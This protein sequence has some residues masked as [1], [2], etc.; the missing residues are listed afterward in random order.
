MNGFL[1]IDKDKGFTSHDVIQ[2]LRKKLNTRKIGHSGTLDPLATGLML[3]GVNNGCKFLEFHTHEKKTYLA[4]IHFG[5]ISN[6]YDAE[7]P[8]EDVSEAIISEEK[9]KA[10]LKEFSGLQLQIPPKYS[11]LK[12]DGQKVCNIMRKGGNIDMK[13]KERNIMI[14]TNTLISY[15]WPYIQ[16]EVA[17]SAGTYIRSLAHDIGQKLNVGA[18]LSDL[19]RTYIQDF[20]VENAQKLDQDV[21]LLP[22]DFG[23]EHD[24]IH[25]SESIYNRLK[26]GQRIGEKDF[27]DHSDGM[28]RL[29]KD[30]IFVGMGSVGEKVLHGRKVV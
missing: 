26:Q 30:D 13:I 18:Y 17:C 27:G 1:L 19:R 3:V 23:L 16:I 9:I 10:T 22:C 25:I 14:H 6:T 2:V 15:N 5:K 24:S 20:S 21:T 7:G 11:A 29:Y 8:F 4:T 12:I 28:Y